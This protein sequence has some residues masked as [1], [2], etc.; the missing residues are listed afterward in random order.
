M[1][2]VLLA[3]GFENDMIHIGNPIRFD[4]DVFLSKLEGLMLAAYANKEGQI[5][6]M[7]KDMVSTYYPEGKPPITERKSA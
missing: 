5:R 4:E 1:V 3:D 7:V 2:Y 6:G